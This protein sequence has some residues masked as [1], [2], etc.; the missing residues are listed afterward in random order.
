MTRLALIFAALLAAAPALAQEKLT[1]AD[2]GAEGCRCALAAVTM[3]EA[4][5][6]LGTPAPEGSSVLV[7]LNGDY[8]L[9]VV[10]T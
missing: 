10:R 1:V 5:I 3:E 8:R 7:R 9:R 6:L 4:G 2:C